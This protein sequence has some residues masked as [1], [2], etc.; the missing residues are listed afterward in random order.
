M[1]NFTEEQLKTLSA[2]IQSLLLAH[3]FEEQLIT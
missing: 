3:P 1:T 2:E